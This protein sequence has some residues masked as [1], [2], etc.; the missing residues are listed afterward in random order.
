MEYG[1]KVISAFVSF[2]IL[3]AICLGMDYFTSIDWY[4][5]MAVIALWYACSANIGVSI[6]QEGMK[7]FAHELVLFLSRN[8]EI[9]EDETPN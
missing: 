1:V 3:S 5:M 4:K 9:K 2:A 6:L 8:V 7:H